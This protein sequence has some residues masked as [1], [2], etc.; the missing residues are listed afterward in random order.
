MKNPVT[1]AGIEPETF[2]FVAQHFKHCSTAVPHRHEYREYFLG[3]KG[4]RCLDVTHGSLN[5]LE[6]S[7]P[8]IRLYWDCL[9]LNFTVDTDAMWQDV[10]KHPKRMVGKFIQ[11]H[12]CLHFT[13]IKSNP[14]NF[15]FCKKFFLI[16]SPLGIPPKQILQQMIP[17]GVITYDSNSGH[18]FTFIPTSAGRHCCQRRIVAE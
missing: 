12:G 7:G 10:E 5:S 15:F 18:T 6:A 11:P 17:N 16:T 4:D 2:E 8:V 13:T 1:P 9:T 14:L 3:G